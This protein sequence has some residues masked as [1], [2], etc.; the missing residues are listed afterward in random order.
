MTQLAAYLCDGPK[1]SDEING[2]CTTFKSSSMTPIP[3][4]EWTYVAFTYDAYNKV[5][6][7]VINQIFGYDDGSS[8]INNHFTFDSKKWLGIN[9]VGFTGNIKVGNS[10][11]PF[12]SPA[13]SFN[14][15]LSCLQVFNQYL[16]PSQIQHISKCHLSSVYPRF[17][18]CPEGF[19]HFREYCYK[20]SDT[21]DTFSNSEY[22]CSNKKGK[23]SLG[24]N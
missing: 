12:L 22:L 18:Q 17:S 19:F 11:N 20:I 9:T 10:Q 8:L 15:K 16:K 1:L 3:V 5:G 13:N 21:E 2:T 6:T 4:N 24:N 7:F 23:V 14:G